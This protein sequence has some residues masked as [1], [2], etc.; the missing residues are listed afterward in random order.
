MIKAAYTSFVVGSALLTSFSGFAADVA[1]TS[2][3]NTASVPVNDASDNNQKDS[4]KIE[5][6]YRI[7]VDKDAQIDMKALLSQIDAMLASNPERSKNINKSNFKIS[8]LQARTFEEVL[9]AAAQKINMQDVA[10]IKEQ[11]DMAKRQILVRAYIGKVMNDRIKEENLKELY[12]KVIKDYPKPGIEIGH[13]LVKDENTAKEVIAALDKG[14]KFEEVAKQYSL[15]ESRDKGG[16]EDVVPIDALTPQLQ[17]I[18]QLNVGQHIKKPLPS[19]KGF[20]I[21]AVLS[22]KDVEAPAFDAVRKNL[23]AELF[24]VELEKLTQTLLK[25]IDVK[26]YDD[27]GKEINIM[28]LLMMQ[29]SPES[30][31]VQPHV[32]APTVN[33]QPAP[34]E[35]AKTVEKPS[36]PQQTEV[37]A[38][39]DNINPETTKT[40]TPAVA[41]TPVTDATVAENNE[42]EEE[43]GFFDK[44]TKWFKALFS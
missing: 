7:T 28:P 34:A 22:K 12:S 35:V 9:Y 30:V 37:K 43:E 23:E 17:E 14:E 38:S 29:V 31:A 39:E 13:I 33:N 40:S 16:H 41:N 2:D 1:A 4:A 42:P 5:D 8:M 19:K 21:V 18:K 36:E 3:V 27:K 11:I 20:H 25:T 26:A 15:A 44:V 6:V 24:K 10:E 32:A